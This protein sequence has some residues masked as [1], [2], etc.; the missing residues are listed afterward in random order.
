[1]KELEDMRQ[2]KVME[3]AGE[4]PGFVGLDAYPTT[5]IL[6]ERKNIKLHKTKLGVKVNIYLERK[7]K[8]QKVANV[9]ELS[10]I[11]KLSH[12]CFY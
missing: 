10:N 11:T 4:D 3:R 5:R 9:N 6:I 12:A 2:G 7:N 8:S 1:M